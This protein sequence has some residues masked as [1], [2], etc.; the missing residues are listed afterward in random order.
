MVEERRA[1]LTEEERQMTDD[2][3]IDHVVLSYYMGDYTRVK[4]ANME[5]LKELI[6]ENRHKEFK[7]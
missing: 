5:K 3:K 1:L 6:E 2:L 7:P 4:Q